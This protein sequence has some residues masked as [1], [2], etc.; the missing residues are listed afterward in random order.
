VR[1]FGSR[2]RIGG[3]KATIMVATA[4]KRTAPELSNSPVHSPLRVNDRVPTAAQSGIEN[5]PAAKGS[6]THG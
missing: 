5:L 3:A 2:E 6:V 4:P 1:F